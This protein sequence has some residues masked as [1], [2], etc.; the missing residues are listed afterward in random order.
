L[1]KCLENEC[2]I[3]ANV[4]VQGIHIIELFV[5]H[6]W[7]WKSNKMKDIKETKS[8]ERGMIIHNKTGSKWSICKETKVLGRGY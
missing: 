6:R 1:H 8:L 7:E 4:K 3:A 5:P 2:K